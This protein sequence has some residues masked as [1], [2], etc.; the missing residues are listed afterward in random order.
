MGKGQKEG[1]EV[2]RQKTKGEI[3]QKEDTEGKGDKDIKLRG[4]SGRKQ[5]HSV[6]HGY[7]FNGDYKK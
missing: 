5:S 4:Q 3:G 1:G 7:K 6:I 2:E